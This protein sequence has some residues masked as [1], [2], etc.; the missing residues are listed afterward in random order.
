[1]VAYLLTYE[2]EV[3]AQLPAYLHKSCSR[4]KRALQHEERSD[5]TSEHQSLPA[6]TS[7]FED[8]MDSEVVKLF[9]GYFLFVLTL[10]FIFITRSSFPWE[11]WQWRTNVNHNNHDDLFIGWLRDAFDVTLARSPLQ[12][13]F[14]AA[15][16]IEIKAI[17]N[18]FYVFMNLAGDSIL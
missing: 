7:S 13:L 14:A 18:V 1:M 11:R 9:D 12:D 17:I 4:K 16:R 6:I 2:F 8:L 5:N 3:S 10:K 15:R